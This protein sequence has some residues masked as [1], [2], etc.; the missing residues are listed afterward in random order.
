MF[1]K[2]IK[3]I[4]FTVLLSFFAHQALPQNTWETFGRNR[5][6]HKNFNWKMLSTTNF[7]I[8]FYQEGTEIA[9]FAARYAESDFDRIA[10]MLGYTPYSKTKIFIYNSI[11]DLQQS[12]VGLE[13]DNFVSGGQTNF[14]KSRVEIPYTGSQADFKKELSL[15]IA[16]IFI[17]EMMFGGSLRDMVQS[18][19]LLTLPEWF[20]SGAAA[21]V[22]EGWSLEMDDYMR[23][24]VVNKNLR[25]PSVLAG[26]RAV[27]TGQSIWNFIA[28]RYGRSNIS[29]ILNLTRIIRNEESSI[30]STLGISYNQFIGEWRKYYTSMSGTVTGAY[31]LPQPDF[32]VRKNKRNKFLYNQMAISPDGKYMAYSENNKGRYKINIRETGRKRGKTIMMGGSKVINQRINPNIPLVDWRNNTTLAVVHVKEGKNL[33]SLYDINSRRLPRKKVRKSLESFNQIQA[34]DISDDGSAMVLSASRNGRND[35]FVFDLNRNSIKQITNDLYD[36]IDPQFMPNSTTAIVFS[37]NRSS[38]SLQLNRTGFQLIEKDFDLFLYDPATSATTITRIAGS[39]GN[40]TQAIAADNTIFY[41]NDENGIKNLYKYSSGDKT[42]VQISGFQQNIQ[43]YDLHLPS[44]GLAFLT[45]KNGNNYIG[46]DAGH[47]FT[48]ASSIVRTRRTEMLDDR[49]GTAPAST[50]TTP[51]NT[52]PSGIRKD[53]LTVPVASKLDLEEG[54]VDTDNYQFDADVKKPKDDTD[55]R[56][57]RTLLNPPIANNARK[58]NISVQGP[59]PYQSRFSANNIISSVLIDPLRGLGVLFTI[60]MNDILEDHKIYGGMLGITDLR[61]SNFFG[62]YQ[63]LK[64]RIDFGVRFDKKTIFQSKEN[65]YQ[66]YTL[67]KVQLSASYPFNVSSRVTLAPFYAATRFT[68]TGLSPQQI[69]LGDKNTSFAGI[70]AEYVFDNTTVNGL[71]MIEGTRMKIRFENYQAI[72]NPSQS[73]DNLTIDLRNYKKIH[74]DIIFATRL[75]YGQ[76]GGRDKKNYLQGGMDNWI[77][78]QKQDH[79]RGNPLDIA[80]TYDNRD[81]LFIEFVT[82]LR[83]FNYNK[84]FGN[85]FLLF[86]AEFRFPVIKY[87][88]RGPIT[89]N[90]FKNLQ[91]VAF[92]DIGAAWTGKGPFSRQNS[93]NTIVRGGNGNAFEASVTNFKNPFLSGHG[94][95][96]RTLLLGYYVKFDVAWGVEDF[97]PSGPKY[98]LTFGYDF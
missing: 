28:E 41:L 82:P 11:T 87:F 22:A 44:N 59:F 70:R 3:S 56:N 45:I 36:D 58:Q 76:F 32:I 51:T 95:G 50:I 2:L 42:V 73:F 40:E 1:N 74:R 64:N 71:N 77:F 34:F 21:Y 38:D 86:N 67:N 84:L 81:L 18:S 93:L 16:R 85:K 48:T 10:D 79:D 62:E 5:V 90:F 17:T 4:L 43:S 24:A 98:Y 68:E 47:D 13:D 20:M 91:L 23:D 6:Q 53:S 92:T 15:G 57:R 78:N 31:Q 26:D 66:R 27:L 49:N 75:A 30:A 37:S 63:Y 88:Y 69:G 52:E 97:V 65:V 9:N 35:V 94:A 55:N 8:F 80:S 72:N 54:E 19:Y 60:N 61:S 14:I 25:K 29:N 12:N 89:S 96:I 33:L 46:F 39:S 83:G 7:E